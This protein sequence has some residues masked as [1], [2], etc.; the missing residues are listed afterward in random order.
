MKTKPDIFSPLLLISLGF[1]AFWN[2]LKVGFLWD[3]YLFIIDNAAIKHVKFLPQIFTHNIAQGSLSPFMYFRP[4]LELTYMLDY[5]LWGLT[6]KGF[7]FTNILI[8]IAVS[9]SFFWLAKLILKNQRAALLASCLYIIHPIHV[10]TV[11]CLAGRGDLLCALFSISCIIFYLKSLS[12]RNLVSSILIFLLALLA[13]MSKEN[14]IMLPLIIGFYHLLH[15]KSLKFSSFFSLVAAIIFYLLL[16]IFIVSSPSSL[17]SQLA[18]AWTRIPGFF[19]S[20]VHYIRLLI[21]PYPLYYAIGQRVFSWT[22]GTVLLGIA[23]TALCLFIIFKSRKRFPWLSFAIA[24][25]FVFLIPYS[26]IY[27]IY[28]YRADHHLYLPSMGF[29]LIAGFAADKFFETDFTP[30]IKKSLLGMIMIFYISLTIM[31]HNYW[32]DPILFYK[33]TLQFSPDNFSCYYNL[34][35]LYTNRKQFDRAME[36]FTKAASLN[37]YKVYLTYDA[38]GTVNRERGN[39]EKAAAY[40]R[41]AIDYRPNHVPAYNHLGN[42]YREMG[43]LDQSLAVLQKATQMNPYN[44]QGYYSLGLTYLLKK[45]YKEAESAFL[46]TLEISTE[47]QHAHFHL[48]V[49][50]KIKGDIPQAKEWLR[51]GFPLKK[52]YQRAYEELSQNKCMP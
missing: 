16:R 6:A 17:T 26:N 45:Q 43:K 11:A 12:H 32:I 4:L 10:E 29:F 28:S 14:A 13:L 34:G 24:W 46:K 20:L 44:A 3:D 5:H 37:H 49:I 41:K 40:Y 47:H 2:S 36:Y 7:H 30:F 35:R 39:F 38:M 50:N 19:E 22:Q 31:Q 23:F 42:I 33:R 15:K 52:D 9:L 51:K 25:F 1:T 27:L 8:H 21:I 48:A 18:K